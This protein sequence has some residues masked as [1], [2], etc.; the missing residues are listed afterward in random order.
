MF[1]FFTANL[2]FLTVFAIIPLY[3]VSSPTLMITSKPSLKHIY[4]FSSITPSLTKFIH[5]NCGYWFDLSIPSQQPWQNPSRSSTYDLRY[6][7]LLFNVILY[8][9]LC[10]YLNG[11]LFLCNNYALRARFP[12]WITFWFAS[13]FFRAFSFP[14]IYSDFASFFLHSVHFFLY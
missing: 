1:G 10:V 11:L 14:L 4:S 9:Y 5:G 3:S 6:S 13:L 12:S 2:S 7:I 8:S